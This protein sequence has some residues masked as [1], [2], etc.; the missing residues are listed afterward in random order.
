MT[1]AGHTTSR[2]RRRWL[3]PTALIALAFVPISAGSARLVELAGGTAVLPDPPRSAAAP[4][5]LAIH[6]VSVTVFALVGA[7]Q[8]MPGTRGLRPHWHRITG[9]I[10]APAGLVA[11]VSGLWL[12]SVITEADGGLL[13]LFRSAAGI[14]MA[15][16]LVLGV[17][18]VLHRDIRRHRAWMVRAYAIGLGAGTQVFTNTVWLLV[19]GT[20]DKTGFALSMAAGWVINLAVAEWLIRRRPPRRGPVRPRSVPTVPA[21]QVR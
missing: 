21:E 14:G 2:P 13:T 6:I 7:F 19:A 15:G 16:A 20:P 10:A 4:I 11:A 12:T 17:V 9:R 18:A 3:I 8:F 1:A 5:P